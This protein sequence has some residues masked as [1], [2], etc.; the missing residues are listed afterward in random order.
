M[1]VSS[2]NRRC[3]MVIAALERS[4]GNPNI[5]PTLEATS[6][7]LVRTSSKKRRGIKGLPDKSL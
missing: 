5:S 2:A 4:T 3:D 7:I 6:I 1:M